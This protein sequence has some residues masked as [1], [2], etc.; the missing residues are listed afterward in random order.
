[1]RTTVLSLFALI[2]TVE[3]YTKLDIVKGRA[4]TRIAF[5]FMSH[6]YE[7]I[8]NIS[9]LSSEL[10]H[11]KVREKVISDLFD[12]CVKNISKEEIDIIKYS[13]GKYSY[14]N[15][16]H[17]YNLD[18]ENYKTEQDLVISDE[19]RKFRK[20]ISKVNNTQAEENKKSHIIGDP[21]KVKEA[22]NLNQKTKT[23]L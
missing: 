8:L 3:S 1:M 7:E 14:K 17:L 23:E 18:P 5:D 15:Y 21:K 12:Q 9:K 4:C 16:S 2:F 22:I 20:L 10:S 11:D 19:H 6:G 13:M